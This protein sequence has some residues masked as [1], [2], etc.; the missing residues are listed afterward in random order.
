M[1]DRKCSAFVVKVVKEELDAIPEAC[2][3]KGPYLCY[4]LRSVVSPARTYSGSTNDFPHRLRQHNGLLAGGAVMTKT[5]K[6]WRVAAL[7]YGFSS[8]TTAL[9]YEW[10]TK[11]RHSKTWR[12]AAR[13]GKNALQRRAALLM[14][15]EL[16][17]KPEERRLLTYHIPDYYFRRCLQEARDDGVPGT[18]DAMFAKVKNVQ[19]E[20][21]ED[22]HDQRAISG[23]DPG[24]DA[25]QERPDGCGGRDE[26]QPDS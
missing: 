25:S 15:A 9:R 16:K 18:I 26:A 8:R 1:T 19:E 5:S 10:F 7:V 22:E 17:L 3:T 23:C 4:I 6:P 21:I 24:G 2:K 11:M 13:E 20:K 14:T 12:V